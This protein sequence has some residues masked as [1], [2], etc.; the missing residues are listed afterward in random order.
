M[1]LALSA[2]YLIGLLESAFV[3]V[4]L[5]SNR[6]RVFI[7]NNTVFV[8]SYFAAAWTLGGFSGIYS[9]PFGLIAAQA[10]SLALYYRASSEILADIAGAAKTGVS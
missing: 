8:V 6:S 3:Q 1:F 10:I 2:W 7:A 5:A 4:C 9:I